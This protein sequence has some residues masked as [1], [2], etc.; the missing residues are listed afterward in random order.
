MDWKSIAGAVAPYAP[1]LG[2]VLGTAIGGPFGAAIGGLAGTAIA[3]AFGVE[4]TPEAVGAAIAQRSD[5]VEK[6][7]LLEATEGER[8]RAAAQ[9][10]IESLKNQ[11]EQSKTINETV[12][13]EIAAGVSWWH[14]RHLLGYVTVV[15]GAVIVVAFAKYTFI[16]G[17]LP[18]FTALVAQASIIFG[19]LAALN[20]YVA[21][22]TTNRIN[23]AVTGEHSAGG[24]MNTLR[25]VLVKK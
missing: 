8:I 5:A 20:G 6:L 18:N 1:K 10:E 14:W 13:T 16:G 2:A 25:T 7:R 9:I 11:T 23:T 12:R 4:A 15:F 19:I 22:D 24:V 21:M 17:D 3:A